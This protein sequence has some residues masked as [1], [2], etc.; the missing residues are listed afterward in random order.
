MTKAKILLITDVWGWG[1]HHRGEQIVNWLSDEFEF[2]LITKEMFA[3]KQYKLKIDEYDL[4]YPLFH[5]QLQLKDLQDRMDKVVT[6]V[7]VR[8]PIK[9]KF[10]RPGVSAK[11]GFLRLANKCR[12]VFVN[13]ILALNELRTYYKG[14]TFYVP[15]GVD[16]KLFSYSPY[17]SGRFTACFV[18]KGH[19][20]EKGYF[21]YIVPA[22]VRSN[23][24]IIS[25]IKNYRNADTQDILKEQ[26][27]DR[28]HVLMVASTF[29]GTPNPA[30]EA[31]SCGRPIL[32]NRIGNMPEFIENGVNGFLVRRNIEDYAEKLRWMSRNNAKCDKM[33]Q[34]ARKKIEDEWCW[35]ETL[36]KYER[37]A[38]RAVLK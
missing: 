6:V 4:Y 28:A 30:L 18:G 22:C 26:I 24:R 9:E 1:G 12:A 3:K 25:N 35:R 20:P 7:T 23:T 2:E 33:G 31:A 21:H 29:D 5:V 14:E 37:P 15:R 19:M 13:N 17:P 36:N 16:E 32:S 38:L 8:Q 11:E 34:R 27:Y 10:A